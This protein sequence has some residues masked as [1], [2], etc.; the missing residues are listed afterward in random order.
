MYSLLKFWRLKYKQFSVLSAG[1]WGGEEGVCAGKGKLPRGN[2]VPKDLEA[3]YFSW[4]SSQKSLQ[5]SSLQMH[6]Q[7]GNKRSVTE[8][9]N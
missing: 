6:N 7:K 3:L 1:G 8:A 9:Y 5:H 4:D 2:N